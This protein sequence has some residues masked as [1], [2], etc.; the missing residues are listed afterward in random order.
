MVAAL[1]LADEAAF[2]EELADV[3]PTALADVGAG[4]FA[5]ASAAFD[6]THGAVVEL[7]DAH[8]LPAGAL[9]LVDEA[10]TTVFGQ[11]PIV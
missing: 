6:V 2:D 10:F 1:F 3:A 5:G 4:M 7:P 11:A 9:A 8:E